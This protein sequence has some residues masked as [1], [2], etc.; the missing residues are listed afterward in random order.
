[1][2]V[3]YFFILIGLCTCTDP[4]FSHTSS[5]DSLIDVE[6]QREESYDH[7]P[8]V[9]Y[10]AMEERVQ[11]LQNE[12][13]L[14][15]NLIVRDFVNFFAIQE[16]E[17]TRKIIRRSSLY[18]PMIEEALERHN[19]P[20]ELKYLAIVESALNPSNHSP[21]GAAGLW[22]LMKPTARQYGLVSN[23]HIDERMHP[24]KSTEAACKLLKWLYKSFGNWELALAAYNT[25]YGNVKRAIRRSGSKDFWT[26]YRYLPRETR[27]YLPQFVAFTYLMNNQE[28]HNF[29]ELTETPVL[30]EVIEVK[31]Y[32]NLKKLAGSINYCYGDLKEINPHIQAAYVPESRAGTELVIPADLLDAVIDNYTAFTVPDEPKSTLPSEAEVYRVKSGESLWEISRKFRDLTIADIKELNNLQ[33]NTIRPGQELVLTE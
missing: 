28:A 15:F 31:D 17:Y 26:L 20:D 8:D 19:L 2:K 25:G 11:E 33:S 10:E 1:M 4:I 30:T 18:F 16:R 24:A 12:V 3:L 6:A 14:H 7:I 22:Q 23:Q 9:P 29:Y 13:P 5:R 32:V 27:S 21:M